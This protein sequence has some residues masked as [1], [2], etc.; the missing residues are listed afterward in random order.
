MELPKEL[1]LKLYENGDYQNKYNLLTEYFEREKEKYSQE[2]IN[3]NL[4]YQL[5]FLSY[6]YGKHQS[7]IEY[8][9]KVIKPLRPGELPSVYYLAIILLIR[10]TKHKNNYDESHKWAIKSL[11]SIDSAA[12]DFDKLSLLK[13]YADL[14]TEAK[15]DFDSKY[16]VHIH[17]V[18][19]NLGFSIKLEEPIVTIQKL[20]SLNKDWN[21][22]LSKIVISGKSEGELK[23]IYTKFVEECETGWYKNYVQSMLGSSQA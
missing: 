7:V 16:T 13:E 10:C 11:E 3:F 17:T 15:L 14:L 20:A 21:L 19:K 1:V 4:N 18:I 9:E 12:S 8:L 6:N 2:I 22:K 23:K 5:G